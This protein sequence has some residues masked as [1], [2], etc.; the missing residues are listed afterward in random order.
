MTEKE[1][2]VR[3]D[4]G[5]FVRESDVKN[6]EEQGNQWL[7]TRIKA[8]TGS[9]QRLAEKILGV[10]KVAPTEAEPVKKTAEEKPDAKKAKAD[11]SA[12]TDVKKVEEKLKEA[13]KE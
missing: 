8:S 4:K 10:S 13:K 5:R 6:V 12:P 3:D 11:P 1:Y 9:R 7:I 2:Y